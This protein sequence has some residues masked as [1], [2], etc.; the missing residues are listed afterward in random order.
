MNAML[1]IALLS[2]GQTETDHIKTSSGSSLYGQVVI[3]KLEI[4]TKYGKL[5]VPWSDVRSVAFGVRPS[6]GTASKITAAI[7]SLSSSSHKERE[8]ATADLKQFGELAIP[9]IMATNKTDIETQ[10]RIQLISDDIVRR[11][12][13][14]NVTT[15]DLIETI[16]MPVKGNILE[17]QFK[18]KSKELGTI[19]VSRES[20]TGIYR[21]HQINCIVPASNEWIK[22]GLLITNGERLTFK[23]EGQVDLWPAEAGKYM[24]GPNGYNVNHSESGYPGGCLVYR[25]GQSATWNRVGESSQVYPNNSGELYFKVIPSPW[26]CASAGGYQVTVKQDRP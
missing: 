15:A 2:I 18:I 20:I 13:R 7:A 1:T 5:I 22:S 8:Q 24:C 10:R 26:N 4:Q 25:I 14:L 21:T 11:G 12:G 17:D 19:A 3:S 23:V 9:Q 6:S 16:E